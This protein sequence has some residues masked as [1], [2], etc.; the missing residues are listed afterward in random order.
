MQQVKDKRLGWK[1]DKYVP[2]PKEFIYVPHIAEAALPQS[3]DLSKYLP[4]VR[5]QG[6]IGSCTGFG[7]GGNITG[8]AI[9]F[10]MLSNLGQTPWFSPWWIYKGAQFIAGELGWDSGAYPRDC[11]DWL[12]QK[13][14]LA[15]DFWPYQDG[16]THFDTTSPPSKFDPE[17]AKWPII[18]YSDVPQLLRQIKSIGF[19]RITGGAVGICQ[20][21]ADAEADIKAGKP[22]HLFVSIGTPWWDKWMDAPL[23][24]ILPKVSTKDY[25]A[26]GHETFLYGYNLSNSLASGQNSWNTAWGKDGRFLMPLDS[27]EIMKKVGGYDAHVI[28]VAWKDTPTPP[29]PPEPTTN[30]Y[31]VAGELTLIPS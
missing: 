10:G 12:R 14:C 7:I 1:K 16:T 5:D 18:G 26:G 9:L 8:L 6:E 31:K 24:G 4:V 3:A 28:K 20:A 22:E 27:F 17:A 30:K 11:L 19:Y 21:L 23:T 13:G 25:I 2:P 29:V 15:E